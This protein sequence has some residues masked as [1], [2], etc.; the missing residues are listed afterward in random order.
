MASN[1]SSVHGRLANKIAVVTGGSSGIGRAICAAYASE[2]AKVVVADL[3]DKSRNPKEDT[4]TVDLVKSLGSDA[5]FVKVDVSDSQSVD[6]LIKAAV[7]K[8]GRVDIMVNNAGIALEASAPKPIWEVTNERWDK[9]MSINATGV[10]YGCRAA[11]KQMISQD[12]HPSGDRGW[13]INLSSIL[14]QVGL[15]GS[16]RYP[17]ATPFEALDPTILCHITDF[18]LF[19]V[20]YCSSK[21][22]V[23]G[24]TKS[25]ALDLAPHR[26]HVNAICPGY[27]RSSMTGPIWENAEVTASITAQHPF[28]G[29]GETKDIARAALFLASEDAGWVTGIGLTVDGGFVAQ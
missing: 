3:V 19:L 4:S 21:H 16:G 11:A 29:L 14:G 9:T 2:G 10:F 28:R 1:D 18:D 5:I 12:P 26:V 22:L 23:L 6:E 20:S 17:F 13:L 7:D 27:T 25:A 15:P 24:L 8:W